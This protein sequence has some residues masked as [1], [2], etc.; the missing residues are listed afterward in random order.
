MQL[1]MENVSSGFTWKLW[2][3]SYNAI[4]SLLTRRTKHTWWNQHAC[5]FHLM[6]KVEQSFTFL[7]NVVDGCGCAQIFQFDPVSRLWSSGWSFFYSTSS[8]PDRLMVHILKRAKFGLKSLQIEGTF[9]ESSF[10]ATLCIMCHINSFLKMS[11]CFTSNLI[12]T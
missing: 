9:W 11:P 7:F 5:E 4:R 1:K 2:C 12:M 3:F 8:S 6:N 10:N